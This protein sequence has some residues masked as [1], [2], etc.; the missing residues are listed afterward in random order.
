MHRR[1]IQSCEFFQRV[2]QLKI[3]IH[4]PY[5]TPHLHSRQDIDKILTPSTCKVFGRLSAHLVVTSSVTG[6]PIVAASSLDLLQ[7]SLGEIL[8][9]RSHWNFVVDQLLLEVCASADK[10][11]NINSIGP[12]NLTSSII[13]ALKA[14]DVCQISTEGHSDW[15]SQESIMSPVTA[16]QAKADIAIVG[17]A[18]RFPDAADHELLWTLLEKGLDVHR[19]VS[20]QS[21]LGLVP[22][23][24]NSRYQK[25][26]SMLKPITILLRKPRTQVI[27]RMDALLKILVCS[28][29][30][31]STC[32]RGRLRRQIRCKD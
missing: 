29:L 24:R 5:H 26:A 9:E 4:G 31:F 16:K 17:M 20:G 8:L 14:A 10:R 25:T 3:P 27:L 23:L 28:T 18:G 13:A 1:M 21:R 7:K 2:H 19:E 15:L 11:C 32:P 30:D 22:Q 12:T 6:K